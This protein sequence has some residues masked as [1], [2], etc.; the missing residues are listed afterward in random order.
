MKKKKK[1]KLFPKLGLGLSNKDYDT[2]IKPGSKSGES[3]CHKIDG[4]L[5]CGAKALLVP[6]PWTWSGTSFMGGD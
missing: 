4:I 5:D 2:L 3:R 1:K 6:D